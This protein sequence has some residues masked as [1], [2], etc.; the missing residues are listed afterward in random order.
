[1]VTLTFEL[2]FLAKEY[3]DGLYGEF[4]ESP[5]VQCHHQ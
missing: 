3:K 5:T 2:P 1:M 4:N